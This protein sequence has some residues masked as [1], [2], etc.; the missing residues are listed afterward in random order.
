MTDQGLALQGPARSQNKT[1]QGTSVEFRT[2]LN[3][4]RGLCSAHLNEW[5]VRDHF[6]DLET[7]SRGDE[8]RLTHWRFEQVLVLL[9]PFWEVYR[10]W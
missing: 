3:T 4:Q 7:R 10:C 5:A 2:E 9:Y 1:G 8:F 6:L